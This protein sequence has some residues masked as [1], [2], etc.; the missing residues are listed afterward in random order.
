MDPVPSP[1]HAA[2]FHIVPY[3]SVTSHTEHRR[4][5]RT[6]PNVADINNKKTAFVQLTK[7]N[8]ERGNKSVDIA[9]L[10]F[11]VSY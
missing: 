8:P 4:I 7:E 9:F 10:L 1:L 6:R 5:A 3:E 2:I 11:C